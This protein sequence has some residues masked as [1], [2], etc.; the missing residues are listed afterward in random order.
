MRWIKLLALALVAPMSAAASE[1]IQSY[2]SYKSWLVACDN[3]LTCVAKGFS[4][5]APAQMIIE[6]AAGPAGAITATISTDSKFTLTDVRLDGKPVDL[7][8]QDWKIDD[9]DSS[10]SSNRLD[11]IQMFVAR[12]RDGSTLTIADGATV[13]LHGF[14]AA[15]LRIDERQ[16][17]SDGVTALVKRGTAAA[18]RVPSAPAIPHIP[19]R[20]ITVKFASGE[21]QRLISDVRT[22]QRE[23]FE[24]EGCVNDEAAS[25]MTPEAHALDDELALILLPCMMGA[26]QGS[27]LAFLASRNGGPARQLRAPLAYAGNK[28][29]DGGVTWFTEAYFDPD[30]GALG[31]SARGRGM[32]DCGMSASWVWNG[33][34][35]RMASLS[36]QAACGGRSGDW[37]MLFRSIQR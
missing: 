31:M 34:A 36:R 2:D 5:Y 10:L 24:K 35:F 1:P 6:R 4:K 21:A 16:G 30:T 28:S 13:P 25:M 20:P 37:P 27:S 7:N 9:G 18:S 11:A 15:L 22:A 32:G 23:I 19:D 29:D 12:L 17:R 14:V 26:Y 33:R 3:G 8:P